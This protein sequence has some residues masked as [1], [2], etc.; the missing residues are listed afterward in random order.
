MQVLKLTNSVQKMFFNTLALIALTFSCF[1]SINSYAFSSCESTN[2]KYESC[3][4]NFKSAVN[5][6]VVKSEF[7]SNDYTGLSAAICNNGMFK[8]K[9]STCKYT[10]QNATVEDCAGI[11]SN[12]WFA[13]GESCSHPYKEIVI[14]NGGKETI[15][16]EIGSGEITYTCIN[17][18]LN[19]SSVICGYKARRDTSS[20]VSPLSVGAD[21]GDQFVCKSQRVVNFD[22][23]AVPVGSEQCN[24]ACGISPTGFNYV[25]S[26]TALNYTCGCDC[27]YPISSG[28][29]NN[30]DS[31]RGT[32]LG[33]PSQALFSGVPYFC[34]ND[35]C[36]K[37]ECNNQ[38]GSDNLCKTCII[39]NLE[40][41][42]VDDNSDG[43][44]RV[45]LSN[46]YSGTNKNQSFLEG[47]YH[48]QVSYYCMNGTLTL[49][50]ETCFKTCR[51]GT[52][53]WG[54]ESADGRYSYKLGIDKF[55]AC[56]A[57]ISD[58]YYKNE[59]R[60]DVLSS[61]TNSGEAIFK[62]DGYEGKWVNDKSHCELSCDPVARWYDRTESNEY[63]RSGRRKGYNS[64]VTPYSDPT[65]MACFA[66]VPAAQRKSGSV[67]SL[68]SSNPMNKGTATM[69]C[70][71]GYWEMQ[72]GS[73][74][75]HCDKPVPAITKTVNGNVCAFNGSNF[76]KTPHNALSPK[77]TSTSLINNGEITYRCNDGEWDVETVSCEPKT[78]SG[79]VVWNK[80]GVS[81]SAQVSDLKVNTNVS[82]VDPFIGRY[83]NNSPKPYSV[84][85]ETIDNNGYAQAKCLPATD[86]NQTSGN[87]IWD[88]T[89]PSHCE[90]SMDGV[91]NNNI[92][93]ACVIGNS[94][95]KLEDN[96]KYEWVKVDEKVRP[97]TV[98]E[99]ELKK[100]EEWNVVLGEWCEEYRDPSYDSTEDTCGTVYTP[101]KREVGSSCN[102]GDVFERREFDFMIG[103]P[104]SGSCTQHF[105]GYAQEC[106]TSCS[107]EKDCTQG[108]DGF[109]CCGS[110]PL[111]CRESLTGGMTSDCSACRCGMWV[112]PQMAIETEEC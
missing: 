86:P 74:K 37:D 29:S 78:C 100:T 51:G 2:I 71:D 58:S 110:P 81:C 102:V 40:I 64:S 75:L 7:K 99:L 35:V 19:T 41:A 73:C 22:G 34:V 59:E 36:Y 26:V 45:T 6:E 18:F 77:L 83:S 67:V 43:I 65:D 38:S 5:G 61:S 57:T 39:N 82:V 28:G 69:K 8:L 111:N 3:E 70:V 90:K 84:Q 30:L 13:D 68:T 89:K 55:A 96:L 62:C 48:G 44:C 95:Y 16:A 11:P 47:D 92:K 49:N 1:Y 112:S 94:T 87:L 108:N 76:S 27:S 54:D 80:G 53:T 72:S 107:S 97:A 109:L 33:S 101:P 14:K 91:C 88:T 52:V 23:A 105:K 25:K 15:T 85:P 10:P 46:V 31:C 103:N 20:S 12:N 104:S 9:S 106:K 60:T 21:I 50:S 63:D 79:E 17:G 66:S 24:S 32:M 56:R 42:N 4:F 98:G 93:G